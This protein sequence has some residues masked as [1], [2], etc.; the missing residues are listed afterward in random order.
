MKVYGFNPVEAMLEDEGYLFK[1]IANENA[2]FLFP[3]TTEHRDAKQ[4]GLSY[5]DDSAGNALAA[6]VKPGRIE[7]RY[8]KSFSD[9]RVRNLFRKIIEPPEL[10]FAAAFSVIYQ[11][12]TLLVG[13]ES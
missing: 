6:M 5:E 11:G 10:A 2:V 7:F 13:Q 4:P 8:H 1:L 12:R 3:H 9:E